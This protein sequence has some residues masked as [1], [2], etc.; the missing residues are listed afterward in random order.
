MDEAKELVPD[1][2]GAFVRYFAGELLEQKGQISRI[3]ITKHEIGVLV[4]H[5]IEELYEACCWS[6]RDVLTAELHVEPYGQK[7][8]KSFL[9]AGMI[10]VEQINQIA[11]E[12]FTDLQ[13]CEYCWTDWKE[14]E[15]LSSDRPDDSP[16][17][18]NSRHR[19]PCA[20]DL[21]P[22]IAGGFTVGFVDEI[23][24]E[25]GQSRTM[26]ITKHE[27]S[28]IV[29][30]WLEELYNV[31]CDYFQDSVGSCDMRMR[32]YADRRVFTFLEARM[33]TAKEVNEMAKEVYIYQDVYDKYWENWKEPEDWD[34]EDAS[35][36]GSASEETGEEK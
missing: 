2:C 21:D 20:E 26:Q 31:H 3:E 7:R 35:P 28:V 13:L 17:D 34:K 25:G 18:S 6:V 10:S 9:E 32:A 27:V 24:G 33:I 8:I 30:N 19:S 5:W 23:H 1:L 22:L 29:R 15:D 12:V 14:P 16:T 11:K 36:T 4:R